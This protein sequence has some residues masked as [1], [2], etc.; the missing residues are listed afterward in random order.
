MMPFVINMHQLF[1]EFVAGWLREHLPPRLSLGTQVRGHYDSGGE[2]GYRID[3]V[4]YD[5]AGR[6]LVVLDTKYKDDPVPRSEDVAQVVSYATSLG[7]AEAVL[8]YPRALEREREFQVGG[9]RVRTV[10][11]ALDG[12]VGE[13]G[14][15]VVEGLVGGTGYRASHLAMAQRGRGE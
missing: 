4:L 8:I 13:V 6:P 12:E 1:E 11:F 14:W 15:R 3:M 7:C 9:V 5:E 2:V 10:G